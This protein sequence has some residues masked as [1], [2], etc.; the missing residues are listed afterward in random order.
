MDSTITLENISN[1]QNFLQECYTI[2]HNVTQ[3]VQI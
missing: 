1:A 2:L 3:F